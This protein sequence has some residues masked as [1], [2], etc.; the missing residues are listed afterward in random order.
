MFGDA[1]TAI[2]ILLISVGISVFI[3]LVFLL[4]VHYCTKIAVWLAFGLA[5][6]LLVVTAI[7][8]FVDTRSAMSKA[9]GWGVILAILAL[10]I[11]IILIFYLAVHNRRISYCIVFLQNAAQMIK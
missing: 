2:D 3:S 8:F 7:V 1:L 10:V 5:I 11:A 6:V 4:L 9:P